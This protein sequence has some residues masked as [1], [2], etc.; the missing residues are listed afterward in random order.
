MDRVKY[1][2]A[3]P[4]PG[5]PDGHGASLQRRKPEDYANDVV[6]WTFAL[7]TPGGQA[8]KVI[9][10]ERVNG[11]F[12]VKFMGLAGSTYTLQSRNSLDA[13]SWIKVVD[14]PAQP[15]TGLR[16]A[17]DSTIGSSSKRFY[18]IVTPSTL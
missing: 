18:R 16:E 4:W 9:S 10:A 17:L 3:A 2:D 13:G 12:L 8:L 11:S 5:E 15:T 7:P 14:L 1:S 6:N